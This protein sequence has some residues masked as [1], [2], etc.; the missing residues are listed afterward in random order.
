MCEYIDFKNFENNLDLF[1][2][3]DLTNII[4]DYYKLLTID[5]NIVYSNFCYQNC[6][7][8]YDKIEIEKETIISIKNKT[9]D[10]YN[11][12]SDFKN[13]N[14]KE[15]YYFK[16]KNKICKSKTST[17][18]YNT[19]VIIGKLNS[20]KYF[21]LYLINFLNIIPQ[22]DVNLNTSTGFNS[23]NGEN[24][25]FHAYQNF[26]NLRITE[27]LKKSIIFRGLIDPSIS[28]IDSDSEDS[29]S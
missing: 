15:I 16:N 22:I 18:C 4:F 8:H 20:D 12:K 23:H 29:D 2:I 27:N 11:M 14:F 21:V 28:I 1:L 13:S 26:N 7:Q 25:R 24:F 9:L 5:P 6:L 19:S 3:D 10:L 17:L